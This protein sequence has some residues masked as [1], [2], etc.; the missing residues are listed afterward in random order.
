MIRLRDMSQPVKTSLGFGLIVFIF[1]PLLFMSYLSFVRTLDATRWNIHTHQVIEKKDSILQSITNIETGERGYIITGNEAFLEPLHSGMETFEQ[2]YSAIRALTADNAR[3]QERLVLLRE[4]YNQWLAAAVNPVLALRESGSSEGTASREAARDF[5][6]SGRGKEQ[7]DSMRSVLQEIGEEENRLLETRQA[8][9]GELASLTRLVLIV[10]GTVAVALAIVLSF[11][12]TVTLTSPLRKTVDY[13]Q[14]VAGGD[15]SASLDVFR[16]D[17]IGILADALRKMVGELT[18]RVREVNLQRQE[19]SA[20]NRRLQGLNDE[21]L[22]KNRELDEFA[23]IASHDLQ[24]PLRKIQTFGERLRVKL[25]GDLGESGLDYLNRMTDAA[26]RMSNLIGSLL[27]YSRVTSRAATFSKVDLSQTVNGVLSDLSVR[28]ESSEA[29]VEVGELPSVEADPVQIGQLFQNLIGNA[30]KYRKPD[31]AP[32]V[33]VYGEHDQT[34]CRV[35]VE[36]NG[37]GFDPQ[38]A[39]IIFNPFQ[40][41]HGRSSHYEGTGMGLAICRKIVE[42]H[43]GAITAQSTPNGGSKFIVTLPLLQI[44]SHTEGERPSGPRC[45]AIQ[46]P[47]MGGNEGCDAT[48][49]S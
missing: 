35:V 41:L 18:R 46:V 28:I 6:A 10:G 47:S 34:T 37:I 2:D 48:D 11:I 36:D 7:M 1:L 26:E 44:D 13:S 27:A 21:L 29:R 22:L 43:G 42:R 24:E 14:R 19:L 40:R 16:R 9:V 17:E 25:N 32:L 39:E 3:Q 12:L 20:V 15:Y 45:S 23:R 30:L 4:R 33:R 49:L 8:R 5:I 38:F 31:E